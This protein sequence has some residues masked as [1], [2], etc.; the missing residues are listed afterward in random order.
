MEDSQLVQAVQTFAGLVAE[1]S[2]HVHRLGNKVSKVSGGHLH[3]NVRT[4]G[5]VG[6]IV[7][8]VLGSVKL[9]HVGKVPF[10]DPVDVRD[11]SHG[12]LE[13][14][15]IGLIVPVRDDCRF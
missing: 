7:A 11:F 14:M 6:R 10:H 12:V 3:H 9:Y 1:F 2:P 5:C 8:V 13:L 4:I 15:L